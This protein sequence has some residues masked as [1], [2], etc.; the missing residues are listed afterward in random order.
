MRKS[1]LLAKSGLRKVKGQTAAIVVLLLLSAFMLNIWLMLS[2][3]YKQNFSRYHE[4]LNAEHVMLLADCDEEVFQTRL[5]DRLKE[6]ARTEAFSMDRALKCYGSFDY[7]GG[8]VDANGF[9]LR[10]DTALNREIGK[11]EITEEVPGS[12]IYLPMLYGMGDNYKT[13]DRI[14]LTLSGKEVSYTVRGFFNSLMAGSHN[15]SFNAFLLT[16]DC[17][18]ELAGETYVFPGT[19]LS[20]RIQDKA[21]SESYEAMV[22]NVVAEEYPTVRAMSNSYELVSQ[23]RYIS[24]MICSGII[25]AMAFFCYIDCACGHRL[26]CDGL[27]TGKYAEPGRAEGDWLY[28]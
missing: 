23:S 20:V 10:K 26:Q 4:R 9:F 3:D 11:V 8:T 24:Q 18:A 17:Y 22:R 1:M 16:E 2:M 14:T 13:G 19:L 7:N 28:V 27:H 25:I 21:E 12:G 6:D 5:A 15:C